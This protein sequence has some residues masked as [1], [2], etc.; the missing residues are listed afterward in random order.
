MILE[1]LLCKVNEKLFGE[2][3]NPFGLVAVLSERIIH[4]TS[5]LESNRQDMKTKRYLQYLLEYRSTMLNYL[6]RTEF[7]YYKWVT[8][9]YKLPQDPPAHGHHKDGLFNVY[10]NRGLMSNKARKDYIKSL[11]I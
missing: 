7:H 3:F 6:R 8:A 9:E 10:P 1:A 5:H 2:F 11:N 4:L